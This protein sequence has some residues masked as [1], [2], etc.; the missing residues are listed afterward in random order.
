MLL[1][2]LKKV[3]LLGAYINKVT[4]LFFTQEKAIQ[5]IGWHGFYIMEIGLPM[6][7]IILIVIVQIIGYLT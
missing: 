2:M 5:P 4:E 3:D 1:L 6:K 7:L